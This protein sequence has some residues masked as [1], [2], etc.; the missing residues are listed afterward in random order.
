[1]E[2]RMVKVLFFS[3]L[4]LEPNQYIFSHDF[5]KNLN[6][7]KLKGINFQKFLCEM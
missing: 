3:F 6:L 7:H 1:M 4:S 5:F 2:F